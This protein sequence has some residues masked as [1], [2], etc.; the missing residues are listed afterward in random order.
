MKIYYKF[1]IRRF[2]LILIL[3]WINWKKK[4]LRFNSVNEIILI[5]IIIYL[6]FHKIISSIVLSYILNYL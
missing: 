6:I 5:A 4:A 1:W 2:I 3:Y